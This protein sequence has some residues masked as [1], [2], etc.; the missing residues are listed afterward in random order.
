MI[1]D[2]IDGLVNGVSEN[3]FGSRG[4]NFE[5]IPTDHFILPATQASR[6]DIV[7]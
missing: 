4:A 2:V 5:L 1:D 6:I 3:E 7:Q